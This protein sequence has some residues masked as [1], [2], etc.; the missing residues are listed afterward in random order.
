MRMAIPSHILLTATNR[1]A[2]AEQRKRILSLHSQIIAAQHKLANVPEPEDEAE[3][4]ESE[5]TSTKEENV[6]NQPIAV[7]RSRLFE[8]RERD[9][10]ADTSTDRVLQHHRM[11]QDEL[12]ES[13]LGMARGLKQQSIAFGEALKEDSKV[14]NALLSSSLTNS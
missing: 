6:S 3:P 7:L 11:T 8:N 14:I 2:I 9:T 10:A 13:M 5:T 1:T 4:E 12:S